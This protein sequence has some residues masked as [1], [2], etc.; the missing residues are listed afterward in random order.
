M[1]TATQITIEQYLA[2]T[3][4]PDCDYIDGEL[5][6][7]NLGK[8]HHSNLQAILAFFFVG[9]GVEWNIR[10]FTEQRVRVSPTRV[11]ITDV[12][13]LSRDRPVELITAHPPL[14]CIEIL[15]D[16]DSLQSIRPR[17]S[18][19]HSFGVN[20]LWVFNPETRQAWVWT[21]TSIEP[22][23]DTLVVPGTPIVVPFPTLCALLD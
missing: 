10:A 6:E 3:Y 21:P 14:L 13:V 15:S 22:V 8:F 5:E 23:S 12:C 18:D 16:G 2:T 20:A 1:A 19:Y 7:R 17:L 9:R 11:R 4:R